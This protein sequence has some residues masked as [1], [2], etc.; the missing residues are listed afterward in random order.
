MGKITVKH[1]INKKL[2]P[3]QITETG[4]VYYPVYVAVTYNRK[5][6][7]IKS[8]IDYLV[9]EDDLNNFENAKSTDSDIY[10][11]LESEANMIN[12]VIQLLTQNDRQ[13]QN[14]KNFSE[15]YKYLIGSTYGSLNKYIL[16]QLEKL[17]FDWNGNRNTSQEMEL[18]RFS[19]ILNIRNTLNSAFEDQ[20]LQY[21]I[22]E[23]AEYICVLC[24]HNYKK[25]ANE[26]YKN[27]YKK[28]APLWLLSTE[29][30]NFE[31]PI[32]FGDYTTGDPIIA[33]TD[34]RMADEFKKYLSA[35][36]GNN[37]LIFANTPFAYDEDEFE[38]E[39]IEGTEIKERDYF[40]VVNYLSGQLSKVISFKAP[41]FFKDYLSLDSNLNT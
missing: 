4:E 12:R 17:F 24:E 19:Y 9:S 36:Y 21:N 32:S 13:P 29:L 7:T 26:I 30:L 18:N 22:S 5:R 2:K 25:Q 20:F 31:A 39:V 15:V 23:L 6:T 33:W 41:I 10:K 14:F 3:I 16:Y 35:K 28:I 34:K 1:F 27:I 40:T 8:D 11:T 38:D 37:V